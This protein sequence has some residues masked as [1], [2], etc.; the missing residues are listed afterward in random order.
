MV[1]T[2]VTGAVTSKAMV[3]VVMVVTPKVD[4][5]VAMGDTAVVTTVVMDRTATVDTIME[6]LEVGVEVGAVLEAGAEVINLIS[7][8]ALYFV[9]YYTPIFMLFRQVYSSYDGS[10]ICND[11]LLI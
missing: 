4:T 7:F 10:F 5:A 6:G 11:C 9:I 8:I 2:E 3:V 1:D